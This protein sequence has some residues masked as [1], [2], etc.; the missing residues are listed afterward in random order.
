LN[1]REVLAEAGQIEMKLGQAVVE[2]YEMKIEENILKPLQLLME[3]DLPNIYKLKRQL[4][5]FTSDMDMAKAKHTQVSRNSMTVGHGSKVD[6]IK[7]EWE[8]AQ[9]KVEQCRVSKFIILS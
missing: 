8:E 7:E 3:N 1:F 4:A 9:V 5:K 2:E 6:N